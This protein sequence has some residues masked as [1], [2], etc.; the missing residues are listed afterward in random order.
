[1]RGEEGDE[2]LGSYHLI[3]SI[4]GIQKYFHYK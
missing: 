4:R 2:K 1:M 3:L